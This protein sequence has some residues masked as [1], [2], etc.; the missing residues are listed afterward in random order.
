MA[1]VFPVGAFIL[2][3][4]FPEV[5]FLLL[6]RSSCSEPHSLGLITLLS[7]DISLTVERFLTVSRVFSHTFS[8]WRCSFSAGVPSRLCVHERMVLSTSQQVALA[9]TAVLFTFVVLPRL[10][11]VGG[12]AGAK[13]T[14]FDPRYT[15]KGRTSL[16]CR[17]GELHTPLAHVPKL[18]TMQVRLCHF[19]LSSLV[20]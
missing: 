19:A 4:S 9:F 8:G 15:R 12:G 17:S 14:R 20:C 13:E 5:R 1:Q 6:Q 16:C 10:F 18:V 3:A 2:K 7:L 11:G